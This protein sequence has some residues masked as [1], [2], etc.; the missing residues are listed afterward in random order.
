MPTPAELL[1]LQKGVAG[2][3]PQQDISQ[4]LSPG[5]A[6]LNIP[7]VANMPTVGVPT[8]SPSGAMVA[9][10][11]TELATEQGP[12]TIMGMDP[13]QFISTMG[14]I[15]AALSPQ[16]TWQQQLGSLAFQLGRGKQIA[17]RIGADVEPTTLTP[18]KK[19]SKL[20]KAPED[21]LDITKALAGE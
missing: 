15:A 5:G 3:Q 19:K 12:E 10:P 16:N 17:G 2:T 1:A 20:A 9:A 6:A 4:M 11:A 7:Q 14:G 8:L 18:E 13:N 21:K